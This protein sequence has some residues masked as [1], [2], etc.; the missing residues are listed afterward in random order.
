M[1]SGKGF[2]IERG[3]EIVKNKSHV[4]TVITFIIILG[5]MAYVDSPQSMNNRKVDIPV[6]VPVSV[7]TEEEIMPPQ[8]P[9]LEY[10]LVDTEFVNGYFVETYR[11]FEIYK[12]ENGEVL[13]SV[14]TSHFDYIRYKVGE[15]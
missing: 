15:E 3:K 5:L 10:K 14:P 7:T 12:D 4:F 13:K 9:I 1:E 2:K 6:S 11:E 8:M